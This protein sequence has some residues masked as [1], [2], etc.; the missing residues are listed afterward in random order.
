MSGKSSYEHRIKFSLCRTGKHEGERWEKLQHRDFDELCEIVDIN[1][2][3]SVQ[4]PLDWIK[5]DTFNDYS[6]V[7]FARDMESFYQ[8]N[9]VFGILLK[10]D[11][12]D[13]EFTTFRAYKVDR[14][15]YY[16]ELFHDNKK[17]RI[18]CP[19]AKKVADVDEGFF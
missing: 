6:R 15:M 3:W 9:N 17:L 1:H 16:N 19:E 7:D 12:P 11:H 4:L 10:F 14:D 8:C 2:M 13:G 5:K 18:V